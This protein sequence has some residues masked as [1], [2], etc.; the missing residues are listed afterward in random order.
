[1]RTYTAII[2]DPRDFKLSAKFMRKYLVTRAKVGA[3]I[4]KP[5]ILYVANK[6]A[7]YS[8]LYALKIEIRNERETTTKSDYFHFIWLGKQ[9]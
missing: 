5:C 7:K 2:T 3:E 8:N 4:I 1:M 9:R 6:V